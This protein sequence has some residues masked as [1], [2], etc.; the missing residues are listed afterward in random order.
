[1]IN[2]DTRR[3]LSTVADV[4]SRAVLHHRRRDEHDAEMILARLTAYSPITCALDDA[5]TTVRGLLD[6]DAS[7]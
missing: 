4:L 1:V 6:D 5:L 3:A 7:A 2:A